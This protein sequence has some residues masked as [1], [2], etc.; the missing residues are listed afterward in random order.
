M[1]IIIK[2]VPEGCENQ[3]K[4]MAAIAVERFLRARDVKIAEEVKEVV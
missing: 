2:E 3:V 1:D 4:E